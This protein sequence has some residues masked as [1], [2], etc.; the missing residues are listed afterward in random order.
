MIA[1]LWHELRVS[2]RSLLRRPAFTTG[3]VLALALGIG[4][5]IALWSLVD[6]VLLRPL[7]YRD[8][9][10]LAWIW[11][12]RTDRDRAF[13]ALPDFL[14][15]RQETRTLDAAL[16][17]AIWGVNLTGG[18]VPER[19]TGVRISAEAFEVLGARAAAG[20][21]LLAEDAEPSRPRVVVLGHRLWQERFG[22][23]AGAVGETLILNAEPYTVVGVARRDFE[24]PAL[25][26]DVMTPLIAETDPL[27]DDRGTSFLRLLGR[28]AP[29][30][31]LDDARAELAAITA[32]QRERYPNT[33]AKK[34]SPR[35]VPLR[36][37]IAGTWRTT[38]PLLFGSSALVLLVACANLANLFLVR[39]NDRAAE[40][41][42][43]SA[44]GASRTRLGL[45]RMIEGVTLS[46]MGGALAFVVARGGVD[47]VRRFGPSAL[48]RAAEI[49]IDAGVL[50]YGIVLS[51]VA[52]VLCSVVPAFLAGRVDLARAM[53]GR[54][55]GQ[56]LR[57]R[58][59]T[60]SLVVAE[61]AVSLAL[62]IGAGLLVRSLIRL[63]QVSPGFDADRL[64][65]IELSAPRA[66]YTRPGALARFFEDLLGRLSDTPGIAAAAA[67]NVL[68]MSGINVRSD[69]LVEGRP[70]A[71]A[72]ETPAAQSRWVTPGYFATLG[73]PVRRGRALA[74]S[75]RAGTAPVLVVDDALATRFLGAG[76]PIGGRLR[77]DYTG[78]PLPAAAIV[79]IVG[80]VQHVGPDD[81]P[82]PTF[83]GPIGQAPEALLP[84]LAD[85]MVLVVRA[86]PAAGLKGRGDPLVLAEPVR[87]AI[88]AIDPD[89]ASSGVRT[90]EQ[91]LG[92]TL[93]PRR[94]NVLLLAGFA[95]AGLLLAC[96]GIY[97]VISDAV[98]QR[99]RELAVRMAI[100]AGRRDIVRLVLVDVARMVAA[101]VL[102]GELLAVALTRALST[103]LFGVGLAD[104]PPG[105]WCRW[106][107]PWPRS[108]PVICRR[109]EPVVPIR[110]TAS[111]VRQTGF[112]ARR[113]RTLIELAA[114][115][116][117][118]RVAR[119]S[120]PSPDRARP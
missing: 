7:P 115:S 28:L 89:V 90:A 73:I 112:C 111:V 13:F 64:L 42:V 38:L 14:E 58:R 37:E 66:T 29:G 104:P 60:R 4:A 78:T 107:W 6:A 93:A 43:R 36:D 114:S 16:A 30:V 117:N 15:L 45:E 57:R 12:T 81:E 102:L 26:T 74:S 88:A 41:A 56:G 94:F 100:G 120:T 8:A 17:V 110:S 31:A 11:S 24:L 52:G 113:R 69:F 105:C 108:P 59:L 44:L 32:A 70:P 3:V 20:R 61:V 109:G 83:Y 77:L 86:G 21:L 51:L 46:A 47:L 101:G 65:V 72:G 22:G 99:R 1:G 119:G 71:T 62:L 79:G 75:D 33:N 68:P 25:A 80:D 84:F 92:S 85:R 118:R 98:S 50:A 96:S 9:D 19:L 103:L 35:L 27:R 67:T 18:E 82:T 55:G 63:Q 76:D 54:S 116:I 87:R 39:A 2:A 10:R 34:T 53:T 95:A 106:C 97:A 49:S 5:N 48:P 91:A 23:R 40:L